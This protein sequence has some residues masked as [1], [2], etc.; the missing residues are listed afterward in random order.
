MKK[1]LTLILL[2][3]F[4]T[5]QS[6]TNKP[7]L[8]PKGIAPIAVTLS[9]K[10]NINS[11][12]VAFAVNGYN[13]LKEQG[14]LTNQR[15]LT[16]AD[17]SKPSSEERL[18]II[19]MEQQEMVLQTFVA[20][21]RNSGTLFAKYFSNRNSSN[22]S[23]LGFY[24][25]GM[26]YSGKHGKSLILQGI[27]PG[28]NDQAKDRAIVLHGADYVSNNAISQMGYLGRSLGC[29]AVPNNLVKNI[30]QTIQGESCLF[31]Y[32]PDQQYLSNSQ[33]IN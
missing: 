17:F 9:E 2:L 32:A 5:L 25:T 10:L 15:Y 6:Y 31:I 28:I 33:L 7:N 23:S 1:Q 13:K 18:Y 21:G 16:I 11:Q 30:I 8:T 20:H 14:R 29:P 12:A 27:E 24:I 26:P 3:S 22:Q 19:D 4:I